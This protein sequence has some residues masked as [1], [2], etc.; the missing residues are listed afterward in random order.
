[1]SE[2]QIKWESFGLIPGLLRGIY[3]IGYE[4]PNALQQNAIM[5]ILQGH[6]VVLYRRAGSGKSVAF[7]IPALQRLDTFDNQC[8]V[9]IL[10]DSRELVYRIQELILTLGKYT[11]P[12]ACRKCVGGSRTSDTFAELAS[13]CQIVV[14]TPGRVLYMMDRGFLKVDSVKMLILDEVHDLVSKRFGDA[15]IDIFHRLPSAK[16]IIVAAP[17]KAK[18]IAEL[19]TEITNDPI[20]VT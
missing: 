6:D 12:F 19:A 14:G 4:S 17:Y 3:E 7:T 18:D 1:M 15:I 20:Q 10:A 16:Q 5:T 2:T 13:A 8:Q 11:E 9:L